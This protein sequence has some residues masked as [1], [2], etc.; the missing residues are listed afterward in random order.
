MVRCKFV[1]SEMTKTIGWGGNKFVW[2]YKFNVVTTGSDENK[3]FYAATPAGSFSVV[4]IKQELFEVG[5][6][7]Y[8]D[9]SLAEAPS[10]DKVFGN[11]IE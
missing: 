7:Y 11:K 1:C 8:L 9:I 10:M 5:K 4:S 6:E 2:S 3:A